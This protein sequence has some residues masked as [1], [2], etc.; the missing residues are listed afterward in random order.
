VDFSFLRNLL[1]SPNLCIL[2]WKLVGARIIVLLKSKLMTACCATCGTKSSRVHGGDIVIVSKTCRM[3]AIASRLILI[4]ILILRSGVFAAITSYFLGRRSQRESAL[5]GYAASAAHDKGADSALA[6]ET[7][8]PWRCR[9]PACAT[10]RHCRQR[11]DLTALAQAP[12]LQA[13]Y[14]N[15]NTDCGGH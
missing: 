6:P 5:N 10:H 14:A 15:I 2:G 3:L 7:G 9:G 8:S 11:R 1:P 13:I 4:L 12:K